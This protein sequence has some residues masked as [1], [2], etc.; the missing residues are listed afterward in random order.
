MLFELFGIP[1]NSYGVSKA[2]AAI[3]AAYLLSR[4]FGRLGWDRERAWDLVFLAT[5]VGFVGGKVYFLVE[6]AGNL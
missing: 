3:V 4:E 1:I 5:V 2:L 6:N